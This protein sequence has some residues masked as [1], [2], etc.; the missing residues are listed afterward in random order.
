[1]MPERVDGRCSQRQQ[2]EN[3][4]IV[5]HDDETET[6]KYATKVGTSTENPANKLKIPIA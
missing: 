4:N 5:E 2:N 6:R 1:M 3:A